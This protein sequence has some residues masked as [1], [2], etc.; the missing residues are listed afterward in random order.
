VAYPSGRSGHK[1][2]SFTCESWLSGPPV[3]VLSQ[4]EMLA[5]QEDVVICVMASGTWC[6]LG[7]VFSYS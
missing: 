1:L 2:S 6:L 5:A 3:C 4:S 7:V